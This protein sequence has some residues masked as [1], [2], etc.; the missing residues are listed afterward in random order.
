MGR[1]GHG[2]HVA[3]GERKQAQSDA[4]FEAARRHPHYQE[5]GGND[6]HRDGELST[7]VMARLGIGY[8]DLKAINPKIIYCAVSGFGH[9][10]PES[11]TAAYDGKI[12]A[13]S[14]IMSITGHPEMGPTRAGFAVCDAIGGMTA[15]FA[16]SAALYQRD[17][18]GLGQMVDV[19]MLDATLSFLTPAVTEYTVAGVDVRQ[20]G[21]QAVS[22]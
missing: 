19:A 15:A 10:G 21:N 18:T 13:M 4:R 16:V 17:Q 8:K 14:G 22:R 12:Q 20:M 5:D 7:G 6:G 1:Q 3:F 9:T 2:A 11:T